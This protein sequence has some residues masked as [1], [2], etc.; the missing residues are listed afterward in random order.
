[1]GG[2][3]RFVFD[4]ESGNPADRWRTAS[5][6][7]VDCARELFSAFGMDGFDATFSRAKVAAFT[8]LQ[9][10]ELF[11]KGGLARAGSKPPRTH[12][13]GALYAEFRKVFPKDGFA[14]TFR[15]EDVT[16]TDDGRPWEQYFRYPVDAAGADW[17]SGVH[18][19]LN[20][21]I[22]QIEL[23]AED[24]ERLWPLI[25]TAADQMRPRGDDQS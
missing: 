6:A 13:L 3:Y 17:P 25:E 15:I 16:G 22:R 7:H 8:F 19:E 24:C 20:V 11:L 23:F 18:I 10:V 4:D 21:W 2:G 12:S 1:M 5:R 14:F 9:G